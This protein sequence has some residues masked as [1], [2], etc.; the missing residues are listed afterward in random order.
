MSSIVVQRNSHQL[1]K[2]LFPLTQLQHRPSTEFQSLPGRVECT[3]VLSCHTTASC[4]GS[5]SN[6]ATFSVIQ[7]ICRSSTFKK[8]RMLPPEPEEAPPL[9]HKIYE[10]PFSFLLSSECTDMPLTNGNLNMLQI[11]QAAKSSQSLSFAFEN[12]DAFLNNQCD[13]L[14][15]YLLILTCQHNITNE[16]FS[17]VGVSTKIFLI[18]LINGSS[19]GISHGM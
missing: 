1:Y 11:Q 3:A 7:Y 18:A 16:R 6:L 19:F 5:Y 15:N 8:R 2:L 4:Y 12:K 14:N 9:C 10:M 13:F 17:D